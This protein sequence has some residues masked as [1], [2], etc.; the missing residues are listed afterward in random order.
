MST[1]RDTAEPTGE[2]TR[3]L[4]GQLG[5]AIADLPV[6]QRFERAREAV[7]DDEEAQQRIAEFERLREQFALARETGQA[8]DEARKRVQS[9]QQELHEL[10]VMQEYLEAEQALQDRLEELNRRISEP[11]SIDFGGEAGGCCRD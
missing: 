2:E 1:D 9:A 11:L 7:A 4:A 5:D 6:Y 10:P 8:T 3:R